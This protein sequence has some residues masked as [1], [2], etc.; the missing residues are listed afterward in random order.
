M[1]SLLNLLAFG[2]LVLAPIRAEAQGITSTFDWQYRLLEGS[3]LLD[4]CLPCARP[5]IPQPLRGS[6][7]LVLI[8]AL[9][10][11]TRYEL[12][13]ISFLATSSTGSNST[14]RGEGT[15]RISG[16]LAVMQ[17]M[18][19]Q[20]VLSDPSYVTTN[21]TFT[22]EVR[23]IDRS[24]PVIEID[25]AQTDF[26]LGHFY[27]L[28]LLAAPLREIWFST[29]GG[30]TASKWQSPTNRV[31][32]GDFISDSG[33]IVRSNAQLMS[34]L[35]LMP[36][37][38]L[39]DIGIDAVDI[40]PGGEILFSLNAPVFSETMGQLKHGDLLS[41][42]GKIF[43]S[44]EELMAAFEPQPTGI[45]YGLDAAQVMADG[46]IYFS[47]TT[48][49][50]APKAGMLFRGD[51]LSD[52]GTRIRSNQ[53]LLSRFH[54]PVVDHDYGLDALRVWPSGEIW[55]STEEGFNDTALGQILAGDILSDQGFVVVHNLE[56]VSAFAPLEDVADFGLDALYI[57]T[58]A[59]PPAAA[60]KINSIVGPGPGGNI[61]LDW[62][63]DGRV[64][65]LEKAAAAT[66][67]FAPV[68]PCM[69]DLNWLD[70][71]A[72]QNHSNG[73]YRLRQW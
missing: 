27:S 3:T 37:P 10:I 7:R 36:G 63:G 24:W 17:D 39:Q 48:N 23:T 13:D 33:R 28:H 35:G 34:K 62:T 43:R 71:R 18:T 47:I 73:F 46:A 50:V 40:M 60:P 70:S 16:Q 68:S 32:A 6:F 25:L 52:A 20:V 38:V 44:N 8:E 12:R 54:P 29:V 9:P 11:S 1:K 49:A 66:G 5:S 64:F 51:I 19:L 41:D 15:Y 42:R 65:Q 4:D 72:T 56:L 31:S 59:T 58:D 55:F 53:Q 22:N 2:G 14:L 61:T 69:V 57:V 45:D 26:D 67:P 21:K 30:L